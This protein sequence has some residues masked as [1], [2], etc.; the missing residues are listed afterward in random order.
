[1]SAFVDAL[2]LGL[3][4]PKCVAMNRPDA[5]VIELARDG[6]AYCTVCSHTWNVPELKRP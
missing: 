2:R 6:T 4:C 1:M 3:V 5:Y